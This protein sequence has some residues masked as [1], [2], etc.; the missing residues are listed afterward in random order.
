MSQNTGIKISNSTML[1]IT[2]EKFKSDLE[3]R[4]EI[5]EEL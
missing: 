1:T 2:N 4:I 3:E 5:G